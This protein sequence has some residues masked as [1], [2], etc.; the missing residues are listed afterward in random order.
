MRFHHY[1]SDRG[2]S[3]SKDEAIRLIKQNCKQALKGIENGN[4]IFRGE[5]SMQEEYYSMKSQGV[6]VSRNTDNYY[7]LIVDN[8]K[9]WSEYPKRSKSFICTTNFES[10]RS[11]G[12]V[13]TVLPY[14]GA[15]IGM[16]PS[17]DFWNSFRKS[18][19]GS[20]D[21]DFNYFISRILKNNDIPVSDKSY[22]EIIDAFKEFDRQIESG[23]L[24]FQEALGTMGFETIWFAARYQ[25]TNSFLEAVEEALDPTKNGFKVVSPGHT[26][27]GDRE[28]WMDSNCVFLRASKDWKKDEG[29]SPADML[30]GEILE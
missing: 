15:K 20:M 16:A 3:I 24:N 5:D 12:M 23:E 7:T 30:I 26:G 8:S 25:K 14:D 11:Y 18:G 22:K 2:Q 10:A 19:I 6:R 21:D 17:N 29:D 1:M 13:Y 28:V 9:R 4:Y 27:T